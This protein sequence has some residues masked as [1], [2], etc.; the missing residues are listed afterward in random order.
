MLQL[1]LKLKHPGSGPGR[2]VFSIRWSSIYPLSEIP[3]RT[4]TH[5]WHHALGQQ[6]RIVPLHIQY[7]VSSFPNQR[8]QPTARASREAREEASKYLGVFKQ[9]DQHTRDEDFQGAIRQDMDTKIGLD[10]S[11]DIFML[12]MMGQNS[13]PPDLYQKEA[14][15]K[16]RNWYDRTSA[17]IDER[18]IP[19][20]F[21][22]SV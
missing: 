6:L 17:K 3:S 10:L 9:V 20:D 2:S 22:H 13:K 11:N 21:H 5:V 8:W 18:S 7:P 14:Y 15:D 12:Q 4:S 19:E 16:V 1:K